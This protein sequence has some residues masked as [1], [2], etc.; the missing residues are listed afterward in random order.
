M[1]ILICLKKGVY[2][3]DWVFDFP[4]GSALIK[5]FYYPIDERGLTGCLSLVYLKI[6]NIIYIFFVYKKW[7]I[8][9]QYG[10]F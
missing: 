9:F 7:M 1:V 8:V 6:E 5:T 4:V 10:L 2:Q 3:K